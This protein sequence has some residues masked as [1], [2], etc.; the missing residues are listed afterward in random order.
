MPASPNE[1]CAHILEAIANI[2]A[3]LDGRGITALDDLVVIRPA[4]ERHLEIISEAIRF[5]PGDQLS[6]F[7]SIPWGDIAGFGNH[8]RHGYDRIRTDVLWNVY[9]YELD[10]L[11]FAVEAILE[12]LSAGERP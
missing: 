8:L 9:R 1:R 12:L 6:A 2:R 4:Y 5:L 7:P 11:E 10:A 3:L